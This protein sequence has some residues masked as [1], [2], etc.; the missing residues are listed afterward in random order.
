M[1]DVASDAA[2]RSSHLRSASFAA[3]IH[4]RRLESIVFRLFKFASLYPRLYL[5]PAS[6][7]HDRSA[8]VFSFAFSSAC[9]HAVSHHA[10]TA[11]PCLKRRPLAIFRAGNNCRRGTPST[12][13]HTRQSHR[14]CIDFHQNR[15]ERSSAPMF[16]ESQ[17]SSFSASF[18]ASDHHHH[19]HRH[20]LSEFDD[21]SADLQ[22]TDASF[23]PSSG[24]GDASGSD[25]GS[26]SRGRGGGSEDANEDIPDDLREALK[27]GIVGGEAVKRFRDMAAISFVGAALKIP[28]FRTRMLADSSFIF[29]LFIQELVGNGTAL[30]LEIAVRGNDIKHE[31]E[32]VASDLIVGAV[33]EA[34]YVWLLAPTLALPSQKVQSKTCEVYR[35]LACE[36]VCGIDGCAF[37]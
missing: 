5:H 16:I 29:K 35:I 31:L 3:A 37:V 22:Y 32:Y 19:Y 15:G 7:M 26:S 17:A 30:A 20:H 4:P 27:L 11:A 1:C 21:N 13:A 28:A 9:T 36:C 23:G 12:S 2:Y 14:T 18:V 6:A 10:G 24:S 8:F 33:V 25:G 34:A